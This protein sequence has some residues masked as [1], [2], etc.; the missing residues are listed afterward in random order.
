MKRVPIKSYPTI[1]M[2]KNIRIFS[3]LDG[4][5]IPLKECPYPIFASGAI[6]HGISIKNPTYG[7]EIFIHIGIDDDEMNCA[8]FKSELKVGETIKPGRIMRDKTDGD[9]PKVAQNIRESSTLFICVDG[10]LLVG[11]NTARKIK[12]VK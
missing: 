2:A 1:H 3:P 12:N 4:K 10:E 11:D 6:G 5:L 8:E 9:Y 7:I